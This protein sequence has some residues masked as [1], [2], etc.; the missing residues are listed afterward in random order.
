MQQRLVLLGEGIAPPSPIPRAT[1]F[2]MTYAR[3]TC[4]RSN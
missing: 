2:S 3:K 1:G 4:W